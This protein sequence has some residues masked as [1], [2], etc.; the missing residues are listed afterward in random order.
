MKKTWKEEADAK[1]A[2]MSKDL[3]GKVVKAVNIVTDYQGS[4][5]TINLVF[6]DGTELD[7]MSSSGGCSE[8]DPD[9]MGGTIDVGFSGK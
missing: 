1:F 7:V 9:G 3:I 8:C 4:E 5:K 2:K 6:E